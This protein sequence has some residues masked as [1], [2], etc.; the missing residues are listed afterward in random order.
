[1]AVFD[2]IIPS[3]NNQKELISCLKGFENQTFKDF[4]IYVCIDGSTDDSVVAVKQLNTNLNYEV[5]EHP[6]KRNQGR[7][8]TRN[9]ALPYI[10]SD[11]ILFFDS[12]ITPYPDLIKNHHQILSQKTCISVG[13][14]DYLNK[15]QDLW[16]G[17]ISRRGYNKFKSLELMAP[18][19][20]NMGNLAMPSCFFTKL[21]GM[22]GSLRKY[23]GDD[24]EFSIRLQ[25]E[26]QPLVLNN[27]LAK[28]FSYLNK[29]LDYALSQIEEFGS[30]NLKHIH[31]KHPGNGHVFAFDLMVG[32]SLKS[33]VFQGI[34]KEQ[35]A[36]F[37]KRVLPY[38]PPFFRFK[39]VH[40]LSAFYL[41]KG[42][43]KEEP[44]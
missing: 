1:M 30:C 36:L 6:D 44:K 15:N 7:N 29:T 42:F 18:E 38:L 21:K 40:Y 32:K 41:Y 5:L 25:K 8:S 33:Q 43:T 4:K 17:Y 2:I 23:G 39:A 19:Y 24:S 27:N 9:L 35:L 28:G 20:M 11:F 12:D 34:M 13:N 31:K 3:Y 37:V 26:F 16:A 22:D 10:N 14:V